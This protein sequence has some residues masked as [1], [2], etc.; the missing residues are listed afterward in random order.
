MSRVA[1]ATS[2]PE[3]E[4]G[5]LSVVRQMAAMVNKTGDR[6]LADKYA[7]KTAFKLAGYMQ[8]P[9]STEAVR[10]EFQKIKGKRPIEV[11][12]GETDDSARGPRG[13]PSGNAGEP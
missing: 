12:S 11:A 10:T 8:L 6:V 9:V 5:Q 4:K 1:V 3:T 7:Q 2:Q 13:S